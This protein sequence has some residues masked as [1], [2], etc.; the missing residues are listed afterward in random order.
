MS[1]LRHLSYYRDRLQLCNLSGTAPICVSV[2]A[3]MDSGSQHTYQVVWEKHYNTRK[4]NRS[5]KA[6]V[7]ITP[8][9]A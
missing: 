5:K 3:I 8:P 2:R 4:K 7:I 6:N 1:A 9:G